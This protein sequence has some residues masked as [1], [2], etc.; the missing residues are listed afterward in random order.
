[1]AVFD[2][3]KFC[4]LD[5][6]DR[7]STLRYFWD[8]LVD[9]YAIEWMMRED[10][11]TDPRQPESQEAVVKILNQAADAKW[12]TF[13]SPGEGE[14]CR[15]ATDTLAGSALVWNQQTVIH[16]QVFP[17]RPAEQ[18]GPDAYHPRIHRRYSCGS[19]P[20]RIY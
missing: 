13:R 2:K 18:D 20:E 17:S 3:D 4:G 19:G 12:E 6:F 9:S 14:E 5:L 8:S 7:H 11:K 15:F 1:M 16:M 10:D